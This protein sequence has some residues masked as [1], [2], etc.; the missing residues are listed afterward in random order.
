MSVHL[1]SRAIRT[2]R[3]ARP[4]LTLV[5][6]A[7]LLAACTRS[8]GLVVAG[9]TSLLPLVEVLAR[10]YEAAGGPRVSL[11]GGGST[12]GLVAV[13]SKVAEV[14]MVS[15]D[16]TPEEE[17]EGFQAHVIAYDVLAIVVHPSN[18]VDGLTREQLRRLMAGQITDWAEVG[19]LPGPV[20]LVNREWGSGS[21]DAIERLVGPTRHDTAVL[22]ANGF[23]RLV[24]RQ[25]PSAVGYLSL[26]VARAGGVKL[27]RVDG[28]LPGE[29]GYPLVRPLTLVTLGPPD[30]EAQAFLDFVLGP[31]GQRLVAEQGMLPAR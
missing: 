24:V 16:L 10:A 17:R 6:L 19:G 9:S 15:R 28:R 23:I 3:G 11:Q 25:A 12:A 5:L 14:A 13:R 18:P 31:T 1:P 29:P 21:R 27:L 26:S 7:A 30:R 20:H 22:N 8:A 4:S 2:W